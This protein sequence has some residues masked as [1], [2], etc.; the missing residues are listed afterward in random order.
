MRRGRASL[1]HRLTSKLLDLRHSLE[2]DLAGLI[3][4]G[5]AVDE[6]AFPE[7][8]V[9]GINC[10]HELGIPWLGEQV[11]LMLLLGSQGG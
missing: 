7:L 3:G 11:G 8:L 1:A 5:I 6:R 10:A 4:G 2:S 9:H